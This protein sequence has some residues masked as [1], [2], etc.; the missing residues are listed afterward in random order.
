[1]VRARYTGTVSADRGALRTQHTGL[2]RTALLELQSRFLAPSAIPSPP[3]D[4]EVEQSLASNGNVRL[5][6]TICVDR[7]WSNRVGEDRRILRLN[8][9][10]EVILTVH[11]DANAHVGIVRAQ[12]YEPVVMPGRGYP[13]YVVL[14]S[15]IEQATMQM[16]VTMISR[17]QYLVIS[18]AVVATDGQGMDRI[19]RCVSA[20]LK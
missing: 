15:R 19:V 13:N 2:I 12:G 6:G 17:R 18:G 10:I 11:L 9:P 7:V 5:T 14:K 4:I 20:L 8:N 16:I 3:S 1:M